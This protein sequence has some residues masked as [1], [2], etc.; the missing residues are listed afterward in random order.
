MWDPGFCQG[1]T[2]PEA[3]SCQHS[4]AVMQVEQAICDWGPGPA[5]EW[6]LKWKLKFENRQKISTAF[7]FMLQDMTDV[8]KSN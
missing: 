2:A 6:K 4:D 7:V 1:G 8:T 5:W 3:K